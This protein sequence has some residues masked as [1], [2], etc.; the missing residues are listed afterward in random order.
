MKKVVFTITLLFIVQFCI[1][2]RGQTIAY[3][4]ME[5]ILENV[6]EY[7]DAQKTLDTKVEEWKSN[8][9]KFERKIEVLKADLVNEKAILTKD[10]IEEREEDIVLE[11]EELMRLESL[12]FGSE[13]NL[14]LFRRQLVK[15]IQDMIYN[16]IQ[17]IVKRKKYDFVFDKSS[18]LMM[19]YSNKK[20]DI[21]E[22]VLSSI[23]KDRKTKENKEKIL[24]KKAEN[25]AKIK[26]REAKRKQSIE[27]KE[28]LKK[29]N[30]LKKDAKLKEVGVK[31]EPLKKRKDTIKENEGKASIKKAENKAKIKEI[32]AK[33]KQSIEKKEARKKE[34]QLKRE[35]RLKKINDKKKLLKRKKDSIRESK[36]K[37]K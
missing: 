10:L 31:K 4:D 22:L 3:I 17:D 20:Y 37:K 14:F 5:Y 2:Q 32:G 19:L 11:E 12:H 33:R 27:K 35:A 6:P 29:A 16:V 18:E 21:S 28:T 30:Q 26:E 7:I 1:A 34:I 15:P 25:K 9:K 23:V 36:K 13:G 24:V 8:L